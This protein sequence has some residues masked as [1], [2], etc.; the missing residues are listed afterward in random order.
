MPRCR[1]LSLLSTMIEL[2]DGRGMV[3]LAKSQMGARMSSSMGAIGYASSR[4]MFFWLIR[5]SADVNV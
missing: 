1:T 2:V 5:R 4:N 3:T